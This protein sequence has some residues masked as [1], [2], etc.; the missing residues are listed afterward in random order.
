MALWLIIGIVALYAALMVVIAS[1]GDRAG[2]QITT[3]HKHIIYSLSLGVYATSWTF[4][5]AVGTASS[6]GLEYLPIYLGP[7]LVFLLFP[8]LIEKL[9][10]TAH[11]Q[12]ATSLADFLSDRYG[13]SRSVA[14]TITLIA[15]VGSLPYIA[16]Q[17]KSLTMSFESLTGSALFS[18]GAGSLLIA[19]GLAAFAIYFGTRNADMGAGNRGLMMVIAVEALVKLIALV[20]VA[21]FAYQLTGGLGASTALLNSWAETPLSD[22]FLTLTLLSMVAVLLLPRQFHVAMVESTDTNHIKSAKWI[23]PLYL[24]VISLAVV[25]I[26]AS[27]SLLPANMSADIYVLGL[28]LAFDQNALAL[29]AFI[30]GF[31][32]ATGM[33]VIS[34][35]ALS[36]MVTRDL[37]VPVLADQTSQGLGERIKLIR[38]SVIMCLILGAYLFGLGVQQSETLASLGILSFAAIIQFLPATLG[39][40]F[41]RKGHRRGVVAGLIAGFSLWAVIL[42]VPAYAGTNNHIGETLLALMGLDL[43]PLTWGVFIS[44]AVNTCLF[45]LV[46]KGSTRQ[47]TDRVQASLYLRG[48]TAKDLAPDF[49]LS[50]VRTEDLRLLMSRCLGDD[51]TANA[52]NAFQVVAGRSFTNSD[53]PTLE[54]VRFV[55]DQISRVTGASSARALVLSAMQDSQLR[56]DDV[57]T[58]IDR[59]SQKLKFSEALLSSTLDNLVHGVS[60]IDKDLKIVAWNKVYIDLFDYPEGLVYVG[61]PIEDIIRYNAEMG[62]LGD[63]PIDDLVSRRLD[64]LRKGEI[65][66]HERTQPDGR[67]IRLEGQPMPG[68]AYVTS[69]SD[70]TEDKRTEQTLRDARDVL[71]ARVEE[72][73]RELELAKT[74]AEEATR[75]KTRFLAAA[76]HDLQQPLNAARL[77]VSALKE[78]LSDAQ[79]DLASLADSVDQ[80]IASADSLIRSLLDISRLDAG[81]LHPN[82]SEFSLKGLVDDLGREFSVIAAKKGL[83]FTATCPNKMI[84]TDRTMLRSILQNLISNAIRYTET[85]QVKLRCVPRGNQLA[86]QVWDTGPGIPNDKKAVIFDEFTRLAGKD[87]PRGVGLGLAIAARLAD[88]L[89]YQIS[90]LSKPGRGSL[91]EVR[92]DPLEESFSGKVIPL[93]KAKRARVKKRQRV[94]CLDDDA[95]ILEATNALLTRWGMDVLAASSGDTAKELLTPLH[96]DQQPDM[97]ILD[98]QLSDG[99]TGID[100]FKEL[101][102]ATGWTAPIILVTAEPLESLPNL[103]ELPV[104]GVLSKPVAPAALRALLQQCQVKQSLAGE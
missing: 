24:A 80:S 15:L 52:F 28:P 29:L 79:S 103:N 75:T 18:S 41:W 66:T 39:A 21:A 7:I 34:A 16:L 62:H 73:T 78:D 23:F 63:G 74:E 67:I 4:Y 61:R 98:Y 54:L 11:A 14:A 45:V 88:L 47:V 99:K 38:R 20:A 43:D 12:H 104:V 1:F 9:L 86:I 77:F 31:S 42:M 27:G 84:E 6:A 97:I 51:A 49:D 70:I 8:R 30:G 17:L 102:A 22:R 48:E 87:G 40:L 25:P 82:L 60:V 58:M 3:S 76:S 101:E 46:S 10:K 91:F 68:G 100:A 65:H 93:R 50:T 94:L 81:G 71:E 5:G 55:E 83:G 64:H 32:A 53:R 57:V 33:I 72:R 59:T 85:G 44:L 35:L 69:F 96:P 2:K 56:L 36:T 19:L 89:G 92:V 90:L 95:Q 13:K 26:A 37:I